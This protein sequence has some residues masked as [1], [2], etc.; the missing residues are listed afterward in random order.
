[1]TYQDND[2]NIYGDLLVGGDIAVF[3]QS[4]AVA[5]G[6]NDTFINGYVNVTGDIVDNSTNSNLQVLGNLYISNDLVAFDVVGMPTPIP[7]PL[8]KLSLK[9]VII[10]ANGG[11]DP[12]PPYNF[13]KTMGSTQFGQLKVPSMTGQTLSIGFFVGQSNIQTPN[14]YNSF[15]TWTFTS[16]GV[17]LT[18]NGQVLGPTLS[19]LLTSYSNAPWSRY[20]SFFSL[21]KNTQGYQQWTVPTSGAYNFTVVGGSGANVNNR[22]GYGG[23]GGSVSATLSLSNGDSMIFMV[24]QT[25]GPIGNTST[26]PG[27]GGG[28]SF[29]VR[30]HGGTLTPLIVA[31][32]GGGG[33]KNTNGFNATLTSPYGTPATT[34]GGNGSGYG[35]FTNSNLMAGQTYAGYYCGGFGGGGAPNGSTATGGGGGG[36]Y[37]GGTWGAGGQGGTN[38]IATGDWS[39]VSTND[40]SNASSRNA[41]GYITVAKL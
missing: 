3:A 9:S 2:M 25:G 40:V 28:G 21:W 27:G 16:C 13:S 7:M 32:G 26:G 37:I 15:S 34:T 11:V 29:V 38:Y 10:A 35:S 33:A 12:G 17:G 20:P 8:S 19:N 14:L 36:G 39:Y 18:T 22:L 5:L 1:M 31:G 6:P 4:N 30:N 24:G 23:Y 41:D